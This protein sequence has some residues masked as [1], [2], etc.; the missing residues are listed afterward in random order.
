MPRR[1]W[2]RII[3]WWSCCSSRIFSYCWTRLCFFSVFHSSH[4]VI[5]FILPNQTC[6]FRLFKIGWRMKRNNKFYMPKA[7]RMEEEM[8]LVLLSIQFVLFGGENWTIWKNHLIFSNFFFFFPLLWL[9]IADWH[10]LHIWLWSYIET[11][12][13]RIE[14]QNV[15]NV[16][17]HNSGFPM[18]S[19]LTFE[20]SDPRGPSNRFG[21]M[22]SIGFTPHRRVIV[23]TWTTTQHQT[24]YRRFFGHSLRA[25][26]IFPEKVVQIK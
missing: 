26:R 16:K 20:T 14:I 23:A 2:L 11:E 10:C 7:G 8:L 5:N 17:H 9:P 24:I 3:Y 18:T 22:I 15:G 4:F 21:V 6:Y 1:A 19:R 25:I 13:W 12:S